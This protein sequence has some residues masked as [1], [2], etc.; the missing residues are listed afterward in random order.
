M[1]DGHPH[2]REVRED[3]GAL[4]VL[5]GSDPRAASEINAALVARRH[6]R[7][8]LEPVRRTLEEHFLALTSMPNAV[9]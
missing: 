7:E 5:L 9:R 8:A 4:R 1:L 6:G 3:D 2:V